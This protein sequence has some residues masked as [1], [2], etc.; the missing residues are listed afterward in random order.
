MSSPE[1]RDYSRFFFLIPVA[2]RNH[3]GGV[4]GIL[5]KFFGAKPD[6]PTLDASDPATKYLESVRP[7]LKKLADETKDPLEVVPAQDSVYIFIGKP[8]KQFGIAWIEKGNEIVNLK[9]LVEEKGLSAASLESLSKE[10][11]QAYIAHQDKPRFVTK[12][13]DRDVVVIPSTSLVDTLK[14]VVAKTV[15]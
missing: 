13:S 8:P 10:L 6:Y 7:P 9:S 4:M 12:I 2:R 1:T 15:G 11:R 5:G 3:K 14:G